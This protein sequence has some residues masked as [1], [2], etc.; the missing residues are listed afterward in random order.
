V[1]IVSTKP[2]N[3]TSEKRR[4][5]MTASYLTDYRDSLSQEVT[6]QKKDG[7][8]RI[9]GSE[10]VATLYK[11]PKDV[12]GWNVYFFFIDAARADGSHTYTRKIDAEIAAL[13]WAAKGR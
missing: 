12:G 5:T 2:D 11:N 3:N 6:E 13:E 1:R 8:T 9:K 7:F 4:K 10:G